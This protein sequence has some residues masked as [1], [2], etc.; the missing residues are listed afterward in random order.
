MPTDA[1][2]MKTKDACDQPS[3]SK[4]ERIIEISSA[5]NNKSAPL[6]KEVI[7]Q[8]PEFTTQAIIVN[9]T[10]HHQGLYTYSNNKKNKNKNDDNN[11]TNKSAKKMKKFHKKLPQPYLKDSFWDLMKSNM[12]EELYKDQDQPDTQNCFQTNQKRP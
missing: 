1:S 4:E 5:T 9:V 10:N 7:Q 6:Q 12:N 11:K 8:C 2:E 3:M